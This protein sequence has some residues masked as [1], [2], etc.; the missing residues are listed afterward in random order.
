M[1]VTVYD[2][3]SIRQIHCLPVRLDNATS[4]RAAAASAVKVFQIERLTN[5]FLYRKLKPYP[6]AI[7]ASE[8]VRA[9]LRIER[10][11]QVTYQIHA[12]I[13]DYPLVVITAPE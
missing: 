13:L 7:P 11:D 5:S 3:I 4:D 8:D 10:I 2:Y 12:V 1:R 6:T 9:C